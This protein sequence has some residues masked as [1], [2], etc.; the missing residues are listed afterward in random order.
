M[1]GKLYH[2]DRVRLG[3]LAGADEALD[4]AVGVRVSEQVCE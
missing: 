2:F 1:F 4:E 3:K